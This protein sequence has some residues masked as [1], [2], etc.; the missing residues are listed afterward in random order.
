LDI[1]KGLAITAAGGLLFTF[2]LPLLRL[3]NTSTENLIFARGVLLFVSITA[4][5]CMFRLWNGSKEPFISGWAGWAI[6][7]TNTIAPIT[8]VSAVNLAPA[9]NVVFITAM[10]PIATAMMAW[11]FL[12]ERVHVYTW[13]ATVLSLA[14][15]AIIAGD[16][17]RLGWDYAKGDVYAM[18]SCLCTAAAF[19]IVRA[20]GKNVA[21]S[22]GLGSLC[23]AI[24]A[25]LFLSPVLTGQ[26]GM[27]NWSWMWVGLAGLFV[28]PL[29]T[30]LIANGPRFLP[31]VDVSMFFLLET[32]L[33]PLWVYL[34]FAEEPRGT[35]LIGG[36]IVLGTL[37]AHSWWRLSGSL[38]AN[39][40][41]S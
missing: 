28:L 5:W 15:I 36:A 40:G 34:I 24:F 20:S 13:I 8:Y 39:S 18:I 1:R 26:G 14:G 33:T 12:G 4:V 29:A 10:I 3:A 41:A 11:V 31:S 22:L 17:F 32:T 30:T 9:A 21:T 27:G 6:V 19:T 25:L 23:S 37:I 16:S 2:E 35:V 38:R 7:A